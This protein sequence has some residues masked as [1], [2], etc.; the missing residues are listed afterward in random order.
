MTLPG[1][2]A[3]RLAAPGDECSI[4]E[5]E[6]DPCNRFPE[7]DEDQPRGYRPTR[8]DGT[9]I[10]ADVENCLCDMDGPCNACL[11]AGLICDVCGAESR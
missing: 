3:W 10:R 1:Y 7:P 6:G 5:E 2:D 8:C 9:M 11:V 4:G